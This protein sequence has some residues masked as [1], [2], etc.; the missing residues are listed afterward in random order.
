MERFLPGSAEAINTAVERGTAEGLFFRP[1]AD[2]FS[3]A[4]NISIDHGIMEKTSRGVVVPVQMQWSDVGAWDAVWKL[5]D[6]DADG[7]VTHGNVVTLDSH[8]S[9]LRSDGPAMIA[10]I[11]VE[12]MAVI[13]VEDAILVAPLDRVA[14]VKQLLS[15][16]KSDR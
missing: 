7:N 14:E 3:Q 8:N 4:E 6:K 2:S 9:L 15:Q 16:L 12:D 13:A 5:G 11:G 1:S 10:A